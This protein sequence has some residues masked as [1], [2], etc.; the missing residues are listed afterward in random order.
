[1]NSILSCDHLC[2]YDLLEAETGFFSGFRKKIWPLEYERSLKYLNNTS[3]SIFLSSHLGD[4]S[5]PS[6]GEWIFLDTSQFFDF[7]TRKFRGI[8]I[9]IWDL[10]GSWAE[11]KNTPRGG[12]A[13]WVLGVSMWPERVSWARLWISRAQGLQRPDINFK[14]DYSV[15]HSAFH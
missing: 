1:M 4:K 13:A 6:W 12:K 7:R 5:L 10:V 11:P 14:T 15:L 2:S 9:V 3:I 8:S